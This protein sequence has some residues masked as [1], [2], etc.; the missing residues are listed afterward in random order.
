MLDGLT[1]HVVYN[2]PSGPQDTDNGSQVD[3]P[4]RGAVNSNVVVGLDDAFDFAS[5]LAAGN[6]I[7]LQLDANPGA[8]ESLLPFEAV[9]DPAPANGGTLDFVFAGT[10]FGFVDWLGTD[11]TASESIQQNFVLPGGVD[12]LTEGSQFDNYLTAYDSAGQITQ[13]LHWTLLLGPAPDLPDPPNRPVNLNCFTSGGVRIVR[14]ER[15]LTG[16]LYRRRSVV[17]RP[18]PRSRSSSDFRSSSLLE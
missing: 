2:V 9:V 4:T 12:A 7:T 8:A 6:R 16:N 3:D 11:D 17:N 13:Q 15:T 1:F 18:T 10:R 5:F 14:D